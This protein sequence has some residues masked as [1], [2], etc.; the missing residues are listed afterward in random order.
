MKHIFPFC[1]LLFS[2]LWANN[3]QVSNISLGNLNSSSGFV[4]VEFD[5]RWE[6]SWRISTGPAN[7]D[8]AWV[9]IKF[10]KNSGAWEHASLNYVDGTAANDGHI[11]AA[12]ATLTTPAD[13]KGIFVYRDAVGNGSFSAADIQLRWNY[14]LDGVN[15]ADLLD[16]Q[17]HAVEMVYVPQGAFS[18]GDGS[19]SSAFYAYPSTTDPYAI[20]SE[21]AITVG[22]NTG[23]LNYASN[24]FSTHGDQLG[25]IPNAFPKGFGAF[26]CMKYEATHDQWVAFFNTLD[27]TQK[28]L[29]DLTDIDHKNTNA[30]VQRNTVLW[31]GTGDAT[32][33]T[34][35][36]PVGYMH[37]RDALAY[38]DWAALRPM[39]EF[40]FEKA[41]RGPQTPV[42][43]E[44]AWGNAN[45]GNDFFAIFDDGLPTENV[46]D[47]TPGD[48]N[49]NWALVSTWGDG[50]LRAG[51]F[52]ASVST[53]NR[54]ETGATYYGI[55]EMSGNLEEFVITPGRPEGRAFT[56]NHGDGLLAANGAANESSWP[57]QTGWAGN[58][59]RGGSYKST[60]ALFFTMSGRFFPARA[61][62]TSSALNSPE[63]G[64]RGIRTAP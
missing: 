23:D 54:V 13:G 31:S 44:F 15:L 14:A 3:L 21:N 20:S 4:M 57:A 29:H 62:F 64:V 34:P 28:S 17:V 19:S 49:A 55:M 6:N 11:Q 56:G 40:E 10:S 22:T 45:L 58:G 48:G 8:A 24:F 37:P 27:A 30:V 51:I 26:Y 52:A 53:K 5:I 38:L 43:G 60:N 7:W 9:F 35:D 47:F 12:G 18:V 46:F 32:T 61:S 39:T 1:A 42:S 59:H 41:C 25:P 36:R 63:W 16:I 2:F 50:P 33:A